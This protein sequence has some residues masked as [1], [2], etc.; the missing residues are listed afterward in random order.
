LKK[1]IQHFLKRDLLKLIK[2]IESYTNEYNIWK[3]EKS[4]N[5]S[6]GTLAVH[7]VG[8]L[9]HYIGASLGNTNYVRDRKFEFSG[10]LVEKK[11]LIKQIED[12][13]SMLDKVFEELAVEALDKVYQYDFFG[14]QTTRFY[15]YQFMLHL[16][17]HLGQ[18]SYHRRLL[19]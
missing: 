9:N 5:N 10:E 8:N 19:D 18:I 15:L 4:I 3:V 2:E 6:A 13:I 17:Y 11:L 12:T 7:I 16:N 1:E 14:K